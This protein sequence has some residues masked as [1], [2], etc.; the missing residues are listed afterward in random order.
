MANNFIKAVKDNS[1]DD[2]MSTR[3]NKDKVTYSTA[4]KKG[5]GEPQKKNF[6]NMNYKDST[7][8]K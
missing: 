1:S 8:E 4:N 5:S 2:N 3:D 6:F 7:T